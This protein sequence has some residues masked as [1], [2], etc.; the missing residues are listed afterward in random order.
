MNPLLFSQSNSCLLDFPTMIDH[1]LELWF[2]LSCLC[3]DIF[4]TTVGK[5]M[6]TSVKYYCEFRKKKRWKNKGL[7][8][9]H[10]MS[11]DKGKSKVF[12]MWVAAMAFKVQCLDLR[13]HVVIKFFCSIPDHSDQKVWGESL[14]LCD[15]LR[16]LD[17]LVKLENLP[18]ARQL[19]G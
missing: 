10:S 2:K 9:G 14:G 18:S 13:Y 5:K 7:R 19:N 17:W 3:Q 1:N 4:N 12:S 8:R 11:R 15:I 16:Y 6:K